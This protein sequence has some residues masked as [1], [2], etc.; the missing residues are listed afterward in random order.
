MNGRYYCAG[1]V[2][3]KLEEVMAEK[4]RLANDM[5]DLRVFSENEISK[6]R[7]ENVRLTC[8]RDSYFNRL[9]ATEANLRNNVIRTN[10]LEMELSAMAGNINKV[11]A[12]MDQI[13]SDGWREVVF[14][15]AIEDRKLTASSEGVVRLTAVVSTGTNNFIR[16]FN[17]LDEKSK[18][19]RLI[20]YMDRI[21]ESG[22]QGVINL[23]G[24]QGMEVKP[25]FSSKIKLSHI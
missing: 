2:K 4:N 5:Q 14:K 17:P 24:A 20:S 11:F 8:E 13:F 23:A 9:S 21:F 16:P 7:A 10:Q 22:W 15:A 18:H 1:H 12:T 6:L 25:T 19:D 3:K